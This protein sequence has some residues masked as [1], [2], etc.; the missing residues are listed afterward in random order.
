MND[1][2]A[3]AT[4]TT[5][6]LDQRL[7]VGE[8]KSGERRFWTTREI[9][10]VRRHYPAGGLAA[11]LTLLPGRSAPAVYQRAVKLGVVKLKPDGSARARR[12]RYEPTPAL[13]AEIRRVWA[14]G[15]VSADV[16]DLCRLTGRPRSWF[17]NRAAAL[18]LSRPMFKEPRWSEAELA[19][20]EAN[21]QLSPATIRLKL[22]R[23]GFARTINGVVNMLRKRGWRREKAEGRYSRMMLAQ[24]FGVR[25]APRWRVGSGWACPSSANL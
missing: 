5:L 17:V 1:M 24:C 11:C 8:P 16:T 13:D 10:V 18:G 20:L 19:M 14:N 4:S 7:V 6:M 25:A 22:R 12:Q 23:A 15:P 9:E 3:P 2:M 21:A